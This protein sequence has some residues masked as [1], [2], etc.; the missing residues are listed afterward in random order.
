MTNTDRKA[1][2]EPQSDAGTRK[3]PPVE[4]GDVPA[5]EED[6]G[7]EGAGTEPRDSADVQGVAA[8]SAPQRNSKRTAG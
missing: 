3:Q 6:I 5:S 1:R 2:P 4:G 8:P 7:T